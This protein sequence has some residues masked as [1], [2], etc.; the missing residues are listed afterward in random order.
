MRARRWCNALS[1]SLAEPPRIGCGPRL[2]GLTME[3]VDASIRA[4][5]VEIVQRLRATTYLVFAAVCIATITM[6]WTSER[7]RIAYHRGQRRAT[8]VGGP[9]GMYPGGGKRRETPRGNPAHDRSYRV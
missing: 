9:S 8:D 3:H 5:D 4:I 2:K 6:L 1:G 7:Q